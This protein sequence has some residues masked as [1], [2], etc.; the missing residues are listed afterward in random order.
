MLI[1]SDRIQPNL[2]YS[3]PNYSDLNVILIYH[4]VSTLP[5]RSPRRTSSKASKPTS[6]SLPVQI[7]GWLAEE[8]VAQWLTQQGGKVIQQRWHCRWGELDLVAQ[9]PAST[10][11]LHSQPTIAFVEVKAR[12]KG[13][14]DLDGLLAI[15]PQKQQKLWK[16]AELFLSTYPQFVDLSCRFDV[17]LVHVHSYSSKD[18]AK[19]SERESSVRS[20]SINEFNFLEPIRIGQPLT[21]AGHSL[22][23]QHYIQSAFDLT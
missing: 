11:S 20:A 23:L 21:I 14:W 18:A 15:T 17:A 13:N 9:F 10:A 7:I 8:L 2:V 19:L 4:F 16:T 22:S 12:R 5:N 3:D 1:D 6:R